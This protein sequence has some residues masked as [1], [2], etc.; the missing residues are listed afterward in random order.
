M[1]YLVFFLFFLVVDFHALGVY[2]KSEIFSRVSRHISQNEVDSAIK[3]LTENL[4]QLLG[5]E[6]A[7]GYFYLGLLN[8]K[9]GHLILAEANF[10]KVDNLSFFNEDLSYYKAQIQFQKNNYEKTLSHLKNL[11]KTFT[12]EQKG[13]I[14]FLNGMSQ[15]HLKKK[16]LAL[17]SLTPLI[18]EWKKKPERLDLLETLLSFGVVKKFYKKEKYCNWFNKIYVEHPEHKLSQNWGYNDS[19]YFIDQKEIKC[20]LNLSNKRSRLITSYRKGMSEKIKNDLLKLEDQDLKDQLLID[21]NYLSGEMENAL[22]LIKKV[23]GDSL[24]QNPRI[25]KK[26][27]RYNYY[28][29]NYETSLSDFKKTIDLYSS[30]KQK[31]YH[32]YYLSRLNINLSNHSEADSLINRLKSR[33]KNTPYYHSVKWY[34][35]WNYY[36]SQR[37]EESFKAFNGLIFELEKDGRADLNEQ[38]KA[39]YW[40]A[41]SLQKA[42][43]EGQAIM[44]YKE[45]SEQN[46]PSYYSI[47]SSLR[48][49][50]IFKR[51]GNNFNHE[52]FLSVPWRK[53]KPSNVNKITKAF[54]SVKLSVRAPSALHIG[55]VDGKNI[56]DMGSLS[57]THS[58]YESRIGEGR[59]FEKDLNRFVCY[60]NLGFNQEASKVLKS[61]ERNSK[62]RGFRRQLLDKYSLISDY[63]ELSKSVLRNF[64]RERYSQDQ[65]TSK[66]FWRLSYP[67]AYQEIVLKNAKDYGVESELIWAHIRAESFYNPKAISSVGARGLLQI[68]PYT[69]EKI[70]DLGLVKGL[71]QPLSLEAKSVFNFSNNINININNNNNLM[72]PDLNIRVGVSYLKRLKKIFKGSYSLMAAAYNGGPHRVKLWSSQYGVSDLDEFIERIPFSETRSYVKKIIFYKYVYSSVYGKYKSNAVKEVVEPIRFSYSGNHPT[73]ENWD[74]L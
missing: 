48:L 1:K 26:F 6:R 56:L 68:M 60:S 55:T 3:Y 35:A 13:H 5:L 27:A 61:I 19:K 25:L 8:F 20:K 50:K 65:I 46:S 17:K 67:Q 49:N 52:D 63:S 28:A 43:E 51:Q 57:L 66:K 24:Y 33:F 62:T 37:Y 70:F 23:Y 11:S 34:K 42:G 39:R 73:K 71:R 72:E 21:F 38:N 4:D 16:N 54:E 64:I 32:L 14:E 18:K 45:L 2:T 59:N 40:M 22:S 53:K 44:A 31:A 30:P 58:N 36:L 9:Q 74:P 12:N 69:A 29:G 15:L 41:R 47:L 7:L 10:N